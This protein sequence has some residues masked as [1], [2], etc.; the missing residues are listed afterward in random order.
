MGV[1]CGSS[2]AS[3]LVGLVD[4]AVVREP[5]QRRSSHLGVAEDR[6]PFSERQVGADDDRGLLVEAA[7][8]MEQQ[9]AAGLGERRI[10][11]FI[12]HDEVEQAQIVGHASLPAIAGL[13]VEL[14]DQIDGVEEPSA[15]TIVAVGPGR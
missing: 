10:A 1:R 13:D 6:W 14:V 12:E 15:S 11:L 3:S 4:V 9:L 2:S 7:D 8:Q 5:V